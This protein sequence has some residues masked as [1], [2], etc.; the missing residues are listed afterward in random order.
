MGLNEILLGLAREQTKST[1]LK[2]LVEYD[3]F[4]LQMDK[5]ATQQAIILLSDILGQMVAVAAKVDCRDE[6][7]ESVFNLITEACAAKLAE[8]SNK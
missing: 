7:L 5:E 2:V 1:L 6:A 8:G 3:A 4:C